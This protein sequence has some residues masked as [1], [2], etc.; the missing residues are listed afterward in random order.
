MKRGNIF[1]SILCTLCLLVLCEVCLRLVLVA[2][3]KIPF[4]S[5]TLINRIYPGLEETNALQL[6]END[7]YFDILL[8]GG[9]VLS[10]QFGSIEKELYKQL[11]N[12]PKIRIHNLAQPAHSSLDSKIKYD[13]LRGKHFDFVIFY[14][15]I[16]GLRANNCPPSVFKPDYSHYAWYQDVYRILRHKEMKYTV[17]PFFIDLAAANIRRK[18]GLEKMVPPH[19]PNEEWAE[20]YGQDIRTEQSFK[21]NVLDIVRRAESTG[22]PI[23]LM[24]FAFYV[25][26]DYS[27]EKFKARQLDYDQ[28]VSPIEIWG[29]PE[30]VKKGLE[31]HNRVIQDVAH[32]FRSGKLKYQKFYY[33]DMNSF[34]PES[35]ENF[36]DVCHLTE[37]GCKRFVSYILPMIKNEQ[38]VNK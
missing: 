3:Y 37:E 19:L 28:F 26:E 36:N 11:G 17:I 6:T 7:G 31:V 2:K 20:K 10:N 18:I 32:D 33:L 25:P 23:L 27:L 12:S 22:D 5:P 16:N 38:A 15:G 34:M 21:K 24:T 29:R 13:L 8:L 35:K 14:H 1:L 4:F 30:N 9:S